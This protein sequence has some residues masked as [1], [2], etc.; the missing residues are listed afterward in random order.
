MRLRFVHTLAYF[1]HVTRVADEVLHARGCIRPQAA[2]VA[3]TAMPPVL[4]DAATAALL[5]AVASAA[6]RER[7]ALIVCRRVGGQDTFKPREEVSL[8][9][10]GQ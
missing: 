10:P 5:T 8:P 1:T 9:A 4:T 6:A 7:R 3:M 2:L